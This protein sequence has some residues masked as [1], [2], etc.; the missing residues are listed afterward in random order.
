MPR[1]RNED[2]ETPK[3]YKKRV[4]RNAE[5]ATE[6]RFTEVESATAP[7]ERDNEIAF[8]QQ[9]LMRFKNSY[10]AEKNNRT[11]GLYDLQFSTGKNVWPA[12]IL[13]QRTMDGRPCVNIPRINQFLRQVTNDELSSRPAAQ[14]N[15]VGD[16]GDPELAGVIQGMFRHIEDDSVAEQVYSRKFDGM[17][18]KGWAWFRVLNEWESPFST[19][20][21][22]VIRDIANDFTVYDD[23]AAVL[24]DRSDAD[25]RFIVEDMPVGEYK[26][27]HGDV[28]TGGASVMST[29]G[30][31]PSAWVSGQSV[32]VAE[33]YY[34]DE[35]K[36]EKLFKL[37]NGQ[38]KFESDLNGTEAFASDDEGNPI[39]RESAKRQLKWCKINCERII[40]GPVD[41][42]CQWIPVV[43]MPGEELN[44][45]GERILCG[46][47]RYARD[48]QRLYNFW[49]SAQTEAIA[50]A[51]K[52]P[53]VIAAG[54]IEGFEH[55]WD[56]ANRRNWSYLPYKFTTVSGQPAPVPQRVHAEVDNGAISMAV[57]QADQDLMSTMGIFRAGLGDVG[58]EKSGRAILARQKESDTA[59]A[60]YGYNRNW[61]LLHCYRIILD[62]MPTVYSSERALRI[63]RPNNQSQVALI[64]QFFKGPDGTEKIYDIANSAGKYAV[65]LSIGAPASRRQQAVATMSEILKAQPELFMVIGDLFID[66]L[67][68][69]GDWK[70]MMVERLRKSLPPHLQEDNGQI[71]PAVV[72]KIQ[73]LLQQNQILTQL[74]TEAQNKLD[75]NEQDNQTKV[76]IA[77]LN[78]EKD[79]L[80]SSMKFD[81][82]EAM[83]SARQ[84]FAQ[85]AER[86]KQAHER[87]LQEDEQDHDIQLAKLDGQIKV[88]VAK[89]KPKPKPAAK[90][91]SK[92]N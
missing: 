22:I 56:T 85:I 44:I 74:L 76:F 33:Y 52:A 35:G 62:M 67:D 86:L 84:K 63:V 41:V 78:A 43:F 23:P 29:V 5:G 60:N 19:D 51:P 58:P 61:A 37:A 1:K 24:P 90:S 57:R 6:I 34:F 48:P 79:V 42:P 21:K 92:S 28:P 18:R 77:Q 65:T 16:L 46:M 32:R 9:A 53:F 36:P 11:E 2:Q 88:A 69:D 13:A 70:M 45:D 27:K 47:V 7:T 66:Q 31:Q 20:Q 82:V 87:R 91:K 75:S 71:P 10:E 38:G 4:R 26:T 40:E 8:I 39:F 30:D 89:A 64:N 14:V 12:D 3:T 81:S 50:L 17:L 72:Q 49:V 25:W 15:P 54:Q 68:A 59:N 55:Y 83:E 80:V 73:E